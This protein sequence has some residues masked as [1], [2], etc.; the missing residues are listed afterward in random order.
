[1]K[2]ESHA[3]IRMCHRDMFSST[4]QKHGLS[5]PQQRQADCDA[6]WKSG[7]PEKEDQHR[8]LKLP[9]HGLLDHRKAGWASPALE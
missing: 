9:I 8:I 4:A 5:P 2:N 7:S 3:H 1:M 6:F